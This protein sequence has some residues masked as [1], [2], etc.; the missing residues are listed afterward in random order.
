MWTAPEGSALVT[1][2]KTEDEAKA[3]NAAFWREK[4][5]GLYALAPEEIDAVFRGRGRKPAPK[6]GASR[7]LVVFQ[8]VN[9]PA[10]AL[11]VAYTDAKALA[12]RHP[13]ARVLPVAGLGPKRARPYVRVSEGGPSAGIAII[14]Y[15][16]ET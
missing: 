5:A 8:G 1:R 3:E 13:G 11:R 2:Y 7:Y 4:Q 9:G 6:G 10:R 15:E 14:T 16:E 12:D